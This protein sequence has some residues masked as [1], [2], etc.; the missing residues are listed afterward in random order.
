MLER[1]T[2]QLAG[3]NVID[4]KALAQ[5]IG[6]TQGSQVED[7][8]SSFT[9]QASPTPAP[10]TSG[11]GGSS[12]GTASAAASAGGSGKGSSSKSGDSSSKSSDSSSAPSLPDLLAAPGALSNLKYNMSASD[13][14]SEQVDLTYQIINLQ[15]LLDR[16]LSDRLLFGK[17]LKPRLQTVVGLNLSVD[18]P[19]DAE[20]AVAVVE[21]TLTKKD[22]P[23]QTNATCS[24]PATCGA[25]VTPADSP[26]LVAAMPQEHTYNS[27]A[28]NSKSNAFGGSAVAK[29][30]TIGYTARKR[31]QTFYMFRDNDTVSFERQSCPRSGRITFGWA[32]RPVLGRKSV[33]PGS[34]QLFAVVSLPEADSYDE[35]QNQAP[36][37]YA[38]E[39][40]AYWRKYD[41]HTL[42]S[43]NDD[44][45]RPWAKVGHVLSLGTSLTYAP[46]GLTK[47]PNYPIDV[48]LTSTYLNHMQPEVESVAWHPIGTKQ[49]F[50]AIKGENLFYDT[51][52]AVGDKLLTGAKDGLRL[53]SDQGMDVITDISALYG[54][55]AILGRYGPAQLIQ[56]EVAFK[57]DLSIGSVDFGQSIG[58]F[59]RLTVTPKFNQGV[60]CLEG[61]DLKDGKLGHPILFLNGAALAG[62]YSYLQY[63]LLGK[64]CLKIEANVPEAAMPKSQGSLMLKFPFIE[65]F[66]ASAVL[67]DPT[68]Q[69]QLQALTKDKDYLLRRMD[70]PWVRPNQEETSAS[71]WQLIIDK[72]SAIR[73]EDTCNP[74]FTPDTNHFCLLTHND[75]FARIFIGKTY[76]CADDQGG[77]A[78]ADQAPPG[79]PADKN[80]GTKPV[81]KPQIKGDNKTQTP[82]PGPPA[83]KNKGTKPVQ[84]PQNQGN[85]NKTKTCG[86]KT[87]LLQMATGTPPNLT[88]V[89]TIPLSASSD[90]PDTEA[91]KPTIDKNQ[92]QSAGQHDIVWRPF[93][94]SGLTAIGSVTLSGS[95]L[96]I[97]PSKDGKSIDVLIPEWATAY[98]AE[99][100]LTFHDKQGTDIG[101]AKVS[102]K[103]VA[104]G[105]N[106]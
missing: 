56:R 71:N 22:D 81:Q 29:V 61:D 27:V 52:V 5:A 63:P 59:I 76:S 87:F 9:L 14:L 24:E 86:P 89:S 16:S 91:S 95:K 80:K 28:L 3:I 55:V 40:R 88:W 43:A 102:V 45:I 23:C 35:A 31:G 68:K 41:P 57:R 44:E 74:P 12:S 98:P 6:T 51:Q 7:F 21:I 49:A 92:S 66:S 70:A 104:A 69:F 36:L 105:A 42:T 82:A 85:N 39:V 58:G 26:S 72:D 4:Q 38:A 53:I 77:D 94:G 17:E 90:K 13:L 100:D 106:K 20:K 47:I 62:P 103:A 50:I 54:D 60:E 93:T 25:S 18:P 64:S 15:M 48:P 2:A 84:K 33:A 37:H 30:V 99:I 32:F 19:R 65:G 8:S 75:N 101:T 11:Q 46:A 78:G 97:N 73:L 34:R 96:E 10:S 79:P 83:D 67:Y 1:L